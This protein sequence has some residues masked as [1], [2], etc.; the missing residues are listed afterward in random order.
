MALAGLTLY[1]FALSQYGEKV[2]WVMHA[3]NLPFRE[4]LLPPVWHILPALRLG[5]LGLTE[6]PILREVTAQGQRHHVQDSAAILQWLDQRFGPLDTL[7]MVPSLRQEC[8][9]IEGRFDD[10]ARDVA[11]FMCLSGFKHDAQVLYLWLH[12]TTPFQ[13]RWIKRGYPLIKWFFLKRHRINPQAGLHSEQRILQAMAW[14]EGRLSDGRTYLVGH[15][16]SVA[17]IAAAS[18][19]APLAC[20]AQHPV[21]GTAD[22]ITCMRPTG[23]HWRSDRPAL[24]WVRRLYDLHRGEVTLLRAA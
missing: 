4:A 13:A 5:R 22:Y 20:P 9:A 14:L 24:A 3:A 21:Y 19:L 10:I 6:L 12:G 23:A 18:M 16:L 7:P 15:R 11:R 17:D 8:L 2:R 1:S